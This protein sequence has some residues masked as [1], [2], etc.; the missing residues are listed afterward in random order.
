M[1][2][3]LLHAWRI[4]LAL[5]AVAAAQ[6]P[7]MAL[8]DIAARIACYAAG[9]APGEVG[10]E[11]G[12]GPGWRIGEETDPITDETSVILR[13]RAEAPHR[14]TEGALVLPS[15]TITCYRGLEVL[16]SLEAFEPVAEGDGSGAAET[17]ITYR[18]GADPPAGR[19]W[20][21]SAPDYNDAYLGVRAGALIL[22]RAL[23]EEDPGEALF[24]YRVV[25]G[26]GVRTVRFQLEG[27][28]ALLPRVERACGAR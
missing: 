7:C 27:L 20:L 1:P 15:L 5:P 21:S 28:A 16:L 18:I 11:F 25:P 2:R 6:D 13:R 12:E 9:D 23:A 8:E 24:R 17:R 3:P 22:A 10:G 26:G 14:D 19:T 4:A